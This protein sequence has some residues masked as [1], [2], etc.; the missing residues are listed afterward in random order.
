MILELAM[1]G[2]AVLAKPPAM[3]AEA[4]PLRTVVYK[5]SYARREELTIQHFAGG[6]GAS[7]PRGQ[8]TSTGDTGTVTIDVYYVIKDSVVAVVTERW[9][10]KSSQTV[11]KGAVA[12]DGSLVE[13]PPE[14]SAVTR[15]LLPLFASHLTIG[16]DLSQIG[17]QWSIDAS[18]PG[19]AI[20]TKYVVKQVNGD[21]VTLSETQNAK[22]KSPM[23]M[24][25][26]ITGSIA[27]KPRVLAPV[28]GDFEERA[29]KTDASSSDDINTKFHF[30]RISDTLD[31]SNA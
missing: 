18:P 14:I 9:N 15:A 25:S 2:A 21:L 17:A 16:T 11:F 26:L 6:M 8:V 29:S 4:K 27:Y 7:S 10:G 3:M 23:A 5:V 22:A 31:K 13:F 30:E 20:G 1:M 12:P 28:S 24:D 19:Y